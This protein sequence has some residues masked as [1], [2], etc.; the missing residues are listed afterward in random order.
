MSAFSEETGI[1]AFAAKARYVRDPVIAVFFSSV[2]SGS[3]Q[4]LTLG[5][6][7]RS[8]VQPRT[9]IL[10]VSGCENSG[11]HLEAQLL[12]K[13]RGKS[14]NVLHHVCA[15]PVFVIRIRLARGRT[16]A[17]AMLPTDAPTAN[18]RIF[19]WRAQSIVMP[20]LIC[21]KSNSLGSRNI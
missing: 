4:P 13:K 19:A 3:K 1:R 14:L 18:G 5:P 8:R 10:P 20:I 9:E 11:H 2:C 21:R 15:Q 7:N 17:S 12:A 16:T 6:V